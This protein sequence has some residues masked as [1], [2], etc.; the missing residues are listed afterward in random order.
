MSELSSPNQ[1]LGG[2]GTG[3]GKI[4]IIL[5][6]NLDNFANGCFLNY[7]TG[8]IQTVTY[9]GGEVP[10]QKLADLGLTLSDPETVESLF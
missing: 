2:C 7:A 1:C 3:K 6:D 9:S 10:S 8:K 4:N 5:P